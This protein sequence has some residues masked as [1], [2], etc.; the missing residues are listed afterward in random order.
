M[1]ARQRLIR[2]AVVW[3]VGAVGAIAWLTPWRVGSAIGAGLGALAWRFLASAR[4]NALENLSVAFPSLSERDRVRIGRASLI[5][6]GRGAMEWLM[7]SR[8]RNDA[9]QRWCVVEDDA[10]IRRAL[11]GGRGVVFV[12]AHSGN[13]ELLGALVV[14][15]GFATTVVA[16]PV[17]DPR[18]DALLVAARAARGVETIS[19]GSASA[20]RQLLSALRRNAVLG[21]L[22]DQDT[23]VDGAFVPFFGRPAYTPTGA[24]ALALRTGASAVC[25][26]LVREGGC[27][28]RMVVQGPITLVRSGNHERDVLENTARFTALIEQHIRSHPEQWVWFHRRWKRR[29]DPQNATHCETVRDEHASSPPT[30]DVRPA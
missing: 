15:Q 2:A 7:V 12:T 20:A 18:L 27:R 25:G 11:D 13:W 16:T 10:P 24:A 17:Y 30:A 6:L 23:D 22:I 3:G 1:K 28:H 14:A 8:R 21:L 4:A 9:I 29:P 19:R 26:F 5:N